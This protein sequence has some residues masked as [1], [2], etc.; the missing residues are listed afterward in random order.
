MLKSKKSK[1]R[2]WLLTLV[3]FA[4]VMSATY[5]VGKLFIRADTNSGRIGVSYSNS[6]YIDVSNYQAISS[7]T[8]GFVQDKA[9]GITFSG[10]V[11]VVPFDAKAAFGSAD[12]SQFS[13]GQIK[14]LV[15]LYQQLGDAFKL[16]GDGIAGVKIT[17]ALATLETIRQQN[18]ANN[19]A[20]YQ[21]GYSQIVVFSS[22]WPGVRQY[23]F[24]TECNSSTNDPDVTLYT[25]PV[26]NQTYQNKSIP[27][28]QYSCSIRRPIQNDQNPATDKSVLYTN[29]KSGS[30]AETI[31]IAAA[32]KAA[33]LLNTND[34]KIIQDT[35]GAYRARIPKTV[36]KSG[37]TF[38]GPV[39]VVRGEKL[40]VNISVSFADPDLVK[41]I[42]DNRVSKMVARYDDQQGEDNPPLLASTLISTDN[43]QDIPGLQATVD[44]NLNKS[45]GKPYYTDG[46]HKI[47]VAFAD[48]NNK[49]IPATAEFGFSI[50]PDFRNKITY[51]DGK[52]MTLE[53]PATGTLG[54]TVNIRVYYDTELADAGSDKLVLEIF[55]DGKSC[56][57]TECTKL[58][59]NVNAKGGTLDWQW[60]TSKG[61]VA[62]NY[63]IVA[64]AYD[65]TRE[66]QTLKGHKLIDMAQQSFSLTT[67]VD[68][69]TKLTDPN[70]NSDGSAKNGKAD[71]G[72]LNLPGKIS[73]REQFF[74]VWIKII[75][76]AVWVAALLGVIFG[77][78]MLI[79]AN[80]D[81]TKLTRARKI[82]LYSLIGL[83]LAI[84]AP[85]LINLIMNFF[86]TIS[87]WTKNL[88]V[89]PG[90]VPGLNN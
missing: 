38:S 31:L 12:S 37:V 17:A 25:Y 50:L 60:D 42:K 15:N 28:S 68:P 52:M 30:P 84:F 2:L 14:V 83:V 20:Y 89:N 63:Q 88:F 49:R 7:D 45:D 33:E 74:Q 13:E 39:S 86:P 18:V 19:Q 11:M 67:T 48:Q 51:S 55:K 24:S 72:M 8:I 9:P 70:S 5:G 44:T 62:S 40:T 79:S 6:D 32:K 59:Q 81:A 71:L 22:D 73:N 34:A 16:K 23:G 47:V 4:V 27:V 61:S 46:A 10:G 21:I 77:G 64:K 87:D 85:M 90:N 36:S 69:A 75:K 57:N 29:P 56:P 3:V 78:I 58:E 80:G 54:S 82:I 26:V 65:T 53:A 66:D 41:S 35:L 43:P 76:Y 1:I